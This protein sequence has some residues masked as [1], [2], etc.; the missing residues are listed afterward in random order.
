MKASQSAAS[1]HKCAKRDTLVSSGILRVGIVGPVLGQRKDASVVSGSP[2]SSAL[3]FG[4]QLK[5]RASEETPRWIAEDHS[6][7]NAPLGFMEKIK[8]D[9]FKLARAL[10]HVEIR[11][12][13]HTTQIIRNPIER[14]L[15][16]SAQAKTF[17][18]DT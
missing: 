10:G 1:Q 8:R 17:R 2:A 7:H 16:G 18:R 12:R 6:S 11:A 15:A 5:V 14:Q 13:S 3:D 4:R 9:L